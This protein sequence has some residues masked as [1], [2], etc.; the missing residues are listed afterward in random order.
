MRLHVYTVTKVTS[1]NEFAVY[2]QLGM[3]GI[4]P[5]RSQH[6]PR[7]RPTRKGYAIILLITQVQSSMT[8]PLRMPT[9]NDPLTTLWNLTIWWPYLTT[10][11]FYNFSKYGIPDPRHQSTIFP[12]IQDATLPISKCF[13]RLNTVKNAVFWD[14]M[15]YTM[16]VYQS[17]WWN[18]AVWSGCLPIF[19]QKTL[20]F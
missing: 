4:T 2:Q 18:V 3:V 20:R 8:H 5:K 12:S 13:S 1:L 7:I 14:V 19:R 10:D 11:T 9:A 15:S 17:W 16:L 6:I